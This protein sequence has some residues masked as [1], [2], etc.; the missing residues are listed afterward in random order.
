ME[1]SGFEL[2]ILAGGNPAD[3][4]S[5]LYNGSAICPKPWAVKFLM[6][7]HLG[8]AAQSDRSRSFICPHPGRIDIAQLERWAAIESLNFGSFQRAELPASVFPFLKGSGRWHAGDRGGWDRLLLESVLAWMDLT[9]TMRAVYKRAAEYVSRR[10]PRG[11]GTS[12]EPYRLD[13]GK[14]FQ[15]MAS[16]IFNVRESVLEPDY[17]DDFEG[18][19]S[20]I[21]EIGLNKAEVL[22]GD[23][24]PRWLAEIYLGKDNESVKL[25]DR[26]DIILSG[27]TAADPRGLIV[28]CGAP[29]EYQRGEC[30]QRECSG[31]LYENSSR[32]I[33]STEFENFQ[34]QL[35]PSAA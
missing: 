13:R 18:G 21:F 24:V 12:Y 1:I 19:P 7:R 29:W 34:E 27:L 4:L 17:Q 5:E 10:P 22:I 26:I 28:G 23:C 8:A 30:Q 25:S 20:V 31:C 11:V 32:I 9:P 6:N 3:L 14:L 33:T 15:R 16:A 2:F 35:G